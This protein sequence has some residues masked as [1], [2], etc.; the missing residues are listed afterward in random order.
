[1]K[2]SRE[3]TKTV[4]ILSNMISKNTGEDS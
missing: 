4:M 2:S 3:K 1:V